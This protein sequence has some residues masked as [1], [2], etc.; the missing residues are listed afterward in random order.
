MPASSAD[1]NQGWELAWGQG[2]SEVTDP[3]R[4]APT[5]TGSEG[6]LEAK[7]AELPARSSLQAGVALASEPSLSWGG[8]ML[9][10][11]GMRHS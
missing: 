5:P 7:A 11:S 6:L 4:P 2:G 1:R 10:G 3:D 8:Q 9:S